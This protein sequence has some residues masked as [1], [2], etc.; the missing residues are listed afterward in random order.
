MTHG[1][2]HDQ[3]VIENILRNEYKYFGVI[4]SQQKVNATFAKLAAKGFS[5][6]EL[7]TIYSPIGFKIGSQTPM[8]VAISIL[9]QL[10]AVKNDKTE[11]KFNANVLLG[12]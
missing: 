3:L 8:E 4:G 1:H 12:D 11:I 2:K 7:Q 6:Q 9:S 10:I 5:R